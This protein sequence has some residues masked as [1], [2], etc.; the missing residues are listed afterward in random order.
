MSY[1]NATWSLGR[2]RILEAHPFLIVGIVNIT[3]DSFYDGG[4]FLQAPQA[5][6]QSLRLFQQGADV[7]DL[8]GE[9][10]RPFSERIEAREELRRIIPVIN[11]LLTADATALLS[12]D[13]YK[14]EVADKV[15]QAGV[16]IINDVS[17]CRFDPGLREV[18]G[19]YKPGYVLMHSLG[20]PEEMQK[21][22]RYSDVVQE[23]HAFFEARM[24][25]LVK[26]GLPEAN[27]VLDPGIGFGKLL[28]HNL[29]ILR[30][31]DRFFDLGR[32]LYMGLSNKSMW[33][34][35]L[36]LPAEERETATQ[37]ATALTAAKGVSLHRV[38]DVE[39]TRQSLEI[40]KGIVKPAPR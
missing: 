23:I 12:V 37:V 31:I 6:E 1:V 38:H 20:R 27:I 34:K 22:P 39:R 17:A 13:T 8:G 40:V 10:T 21:D 14:A 9:S 16:S 24:N 19:E 26:A 29:Q 18:L 25:D 36:G 28:A 30:D 32:P 33:Q 11:Q 3:P 2:G 35:L 15:L 7:V 4:Q 5:V